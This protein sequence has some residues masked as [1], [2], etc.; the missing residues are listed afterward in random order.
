M[1]DAQKAKEQLKTPPIVWQSQY[2]TTIQSIDLSIYGQSV[3]VLYGSTIS[4][5]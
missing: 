2:N 1:M 5:K 4:C 3:L